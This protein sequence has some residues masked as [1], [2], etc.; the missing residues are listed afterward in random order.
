MKKVFLLVF[1]LLITLTA[2]A[3]TQTSNSKTDIS[4]K[5]I[6]EKDSDYICLKNAAFFADGGVGEAGQ[7]PNEIFA[8]GRLF[9]KENASDY[10]IKLESEAGNAGKLY[11]LCGL[12][13]LDYS[14]YNYLMEKYCSDAE[15]VTYMQGC[16]MSEYKMSEII[17]REGADGSPV[18]RLKNNKDTLNAWCARNPTADGFTMDFYGGAIPYSVRNLSE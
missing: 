10:F 7:I 1:A 12:Y 15:T 5:N 18:V 16:I 9:K 4:L 11:A 6:N 2:C 8:F 17:K 14:N 13:Y 3:T